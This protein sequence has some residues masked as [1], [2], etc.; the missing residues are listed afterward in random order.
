MHKDYC[1]EHNT[2][3]KAKGL[4]FSQR[5][6]GSSWKSIFVSRFICVVWP[7][8]LE[9]LCRPT[10]GVLPPCLDTKDTP[11]PL[12][13]SFLERNPFNMVP[14]KEIQI[15]LRLV[16][17]FSFNYGFFSSLK[18]TLQ[19]QPVCALQHIDQFSVIKLKVF[20]L[21]I[22]VS[23]CVQHDVNVEKEFI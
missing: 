16:S 17:E 9:P 21:L 4:F 15:W 1:V 7:Q 18:Q 22:N 20:P 23:L 11:A 19:L 2:S 5:R 13:N 10:A 3:R 8:M 6:E 12:K 14:W